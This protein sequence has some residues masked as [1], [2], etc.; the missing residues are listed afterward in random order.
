[1]KSERFQTWRRSA[2]TDAATRMNALAANAMKDCGQ[3]A[4]P[5]FIL[6]FNV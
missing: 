5:G 3:A 4:Y 2:E 1:M 6:D